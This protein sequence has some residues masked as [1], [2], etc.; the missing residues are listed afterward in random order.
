MYFRNTFLLTKEDR[1][2]NVEIVGD[3]QLL[4]VASVLL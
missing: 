1:I 4:P 3:E 2:F